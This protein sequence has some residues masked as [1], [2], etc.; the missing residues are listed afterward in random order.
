MRFP[1]I[2]FVSSSVLSFSV[3]NYPVIS[4]TLILAGFQNNGNRSAVAIYAREL[5][6]PWPHPREA[7]VAT[8][9]MG[10][11]SW[12]YSSKKNIRKFLKLS[13]LSCFEKLYPDIRIARLL[14]N[15]GKSVRRRADFVF[16]KYRSEEEIQ[17]W[18]PWYLL[19][20]RGLVFGL[21]TMSVQYSTVTV[22]YS[23]VQYS[24]VRANTPALALLRVNSQWGSPEETVF[25]IH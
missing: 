12:R 15:Y 8:D 16:L 14:G 25:S 18:G 19:V 17:V 20:V 10:E 7:P 24:K 4:L 6:R 22:Q 11:A 5:H 3:S 2:K 21:N 9:V 23:T 13:L 1:L